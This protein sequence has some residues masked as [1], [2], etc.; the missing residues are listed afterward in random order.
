MNKATLK[1]AG[2]A[3]LGVAI[4]AAAITPAVA[5]EQTGTPLTGLPTSGVPLQGLAKAPL[6][7]G[8]QA[9]TSRSGSVHEVTGT[10][11][12]LVDT[13]APSVQQASQNLPGLRAKAPTTRGLGGAPS[14]G[15]LPGAASLPALPA[16]GALGALGGL[17]VHSPLG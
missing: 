3:V 11:Q 15:S 12:D 14:L 5:A 17:P 7:D 9:L 1:A 13:A 8:A 16:A 6:A 10:A 2:T 4:A